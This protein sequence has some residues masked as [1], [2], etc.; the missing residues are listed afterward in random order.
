MEEKGGL[1]EAG[2]RGRIA[3]HP[4]AVGTRRFLV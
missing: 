2:G 1:R 3:V 4:A